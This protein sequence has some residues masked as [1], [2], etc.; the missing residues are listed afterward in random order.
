MDAGAGANRAS[1]LAFLY[2]FC[3]LMATEHLKCMQAKK[4]SKSNFFEEGQVEKQRW[5]ESAKSRVREEARRLEK[6]KGQKKDAAGARK[7]RKVVKHCVLTMCTASFQ[8]ACVLLQLAFVLHSSG[9]RTLS[10]R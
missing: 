2:F 10:Q 3:F 7:G 8:I 9:P 1:S 5:E 4:V 6:R